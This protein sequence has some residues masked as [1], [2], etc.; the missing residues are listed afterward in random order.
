MNKKLVLFIVLGSYFLIMMDTSITMTALNEIQDD[1]EMSEGLLTW[2]Q[3]AYVLIFGGLLLLGSKMG[4]ILGLKKI[5]LVGLSLFL[6]FSIATGLA[7][8]SLMLITSRGGQGIAAAL[9]SP[10]ILAFI[11]SIYEDGP[12]KEKLYHFIAQLQVLAQVVD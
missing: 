8:N 2:V 1:L 6:L 7:T 10:S 4:D 3:S 5:F 11:N 9:V 12:E